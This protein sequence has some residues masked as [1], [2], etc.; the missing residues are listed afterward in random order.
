MKTLKNNVKCSGCEKGPIF[1]ARF[2]CL[3]CPNFNLCEDCEKALPIS[4][5]CLFQS[6]LSILIYLSQQKLAIHIYNNLIWNTNVL[7]LPKNA[8]LSANF[9]VDNLK[10]ISN[11]FLKIKE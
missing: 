2:Q 1:G 11:L 5:V 8:F 9:L 6:T 4:T 10:I 7:L 3:D